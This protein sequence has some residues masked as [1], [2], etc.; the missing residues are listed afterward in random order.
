MLVRTLTES[1]MPHL[2]RLYRYLD[3]DNTEIPLSE[4]L[5]HWEML[6]RYPYS[7]IFVACKGEVPVATCSLIVIP[8]LTRIGAPYALIENVVTHP[9]YRKQGLGTAVLHAAVE[10]A[11]L[12]GC[13]KV[14]LMTGSNQAS[15]LKFYQDVGFEQSKTGFQI[16]RP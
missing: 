16:R 8:N 9:D 2:Q 5:Q 6:K 12:A 3:A 10:A 1:D 11:W 14:M 7:D 15:T 13:Y 4:A